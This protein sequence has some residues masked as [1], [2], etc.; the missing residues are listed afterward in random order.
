MPAVGNSNC[1]A[2][3]FRS[4]VTSQILPRFP[5][6][7]E[8]RNMAWLLCAQTNFRGTKKINNAE[9]LSSLGGPITLCRVLSS[10]IRARWTKIFMFALVRTQVV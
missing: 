4:V 2:R 8:L 3:A 10:C 6:V 1:V 7:S 5:F 9:C